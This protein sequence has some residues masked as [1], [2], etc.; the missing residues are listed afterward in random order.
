[1]NIEIPGVNVDKGLELCEGDTDIYLRFLRRYT[2]SMPDCLEKMLNVSEE[3]LKDHTIN[4]HG[5]KNICE[6]IGAEEIA[7]RA[8]QLELMGRD[9]DLAG[10][11]SRNNDFIKHAE[12]VVDA[13]RNWLKAHDAENA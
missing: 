6:I 12:I 7:E 11:L 5:A 13:I 4:A 3:T 9:R 10:V 2:T 8:K 1:M